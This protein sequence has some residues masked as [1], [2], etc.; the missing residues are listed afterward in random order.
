MS[1][2]TVP[3]NT[4]GA[5]L[6]H[7]NQ[8]Q[9]GASLTASQAAVDSKSGILVNGTQP[10][11]KKDD[12]KKEANAPSIVLHPEKYTGSLTLRDAENPAAK[13]EGA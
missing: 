5:M 12:I 4:Q 13:S 2:P 8:I 1:Y 11:I 3:Q 10:D 9:M 7:P 6:L